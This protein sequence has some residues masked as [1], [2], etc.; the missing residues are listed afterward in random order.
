VDAGGAEPLA[1]LLRAG[2]QQGV[3]PAA[4]A[5]VQTDREPVLVA[6]AGAAVES[7]YFD[8]ASLTKAVVTTTL[9]MHAV[10]LGVLDLDRPVAPLVPAARGQLPGVTARHLLSHGS[11]LPAWRPFFEALRGYDAIVAAAASEPTELPPGTR[12]VYSDLGF[13]VLGALLERL[14]GGRLDELFEQ[15]VARPLGLSARFRPLKPGGRPIPLPTGSI[16]PTELCPRRGLLVGTVHD[17]NAAAMGG[18]AGHA[19]LFATAGELHRFADALVSVWRGE[20]S[21]LRLQPATVRLFFTPT[22]IADSTWRL[23]WDGPTPH[24]SSAGELLVRSARAPL[25]GHLGFT[26][27]S[28]WI[29]PARPRWIIL[30]TNRV[31]PRRDNDQIRG[32]R[33]RFHDDVVRTL[34][35]PALG[36]RP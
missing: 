5:L 10:D 4:V 2:V 14:L 18:V 21:P 35:H 8:V 1:L 7:T 24:G 13:I 23:G 19:G 29:D 15:L 9:A 22:A 28:I 3:F 36:S 6:W 31:H 30:L 20:P 12:S 26:G 17:D 16:A 25:V 34:L 27:C 32:F 33:P 11:G